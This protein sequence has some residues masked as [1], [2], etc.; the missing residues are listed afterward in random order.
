MD[1]LLYPI[2]NKEKWRLVVPVESGHLGAEKRMIAWPENIIGRKCTV[3][4]ESVIFV[5]DIKLH[6]PGLKD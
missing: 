2:Q 3:M 6:K 4:C 5:S 1:P